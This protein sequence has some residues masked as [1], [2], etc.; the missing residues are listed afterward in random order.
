MMKILRMGKLS[1]NFWSRQPT[2]QKCETDRYFYQIN[3]WTDKCFGQR[4]KYLPLSCPWTCLSRVFNKKSLQH[5]CFHLAS[6][7]KTTDWVHQTEITRRLK[8][9]IS[10]KFTYLEV[11]MIYLQMYLPATWKI[12]T[13]L[14]GPCV[15]IS[16]CP[17]NLLLAKDNVLRMW[18]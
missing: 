10:I 15:H 17:R 1:I 2:P 13:K 9:N 12:S 3:T 5:K 16:N 6:L 18:H 4:K 14:F 8:V 11:K 7:L